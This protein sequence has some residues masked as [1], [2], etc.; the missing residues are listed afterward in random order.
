MKKTS[1]SEKVG[2]LIGHE[3]AQLILR[4]FNEPIFKH[5]TIISVDLSPDL[6]V[7]KVFFSVFDITRADEALE[8]LE[9]NN[10]VLRHYLAQNL[11]LRI[12][13]K[14]IFLFDKSI[15]EGGRLANLIDTAIASDERKSQNNL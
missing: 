14:L 5:I 8:K 12:T 13:P 10:K 4:R 6:A 1:R 9:A 15:I 7:A 3:L 2:E 11:N